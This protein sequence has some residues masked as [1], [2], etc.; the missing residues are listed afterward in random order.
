M[1]TNLHLTRLTELSDQFKMLEKYS[2]HIVFFL[3]EI[4]L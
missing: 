2:R 1:Q 4:Q 3:I